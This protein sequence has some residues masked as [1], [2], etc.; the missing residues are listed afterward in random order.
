MA[1]LDRP[2]ASLAPGRNR[3]AT[4]DMQCARDLKVF[5]LSQVMHA[6]QGTIGYYFSGKSSQSFDG[7]PVCQL[8]FH[9]GFL[10]GSANCVKFKLRDMDNAQQDREATR[11]QTNFKAVVNFR[12]QQQSEEGQR[13]V[14]VRRNFGLECLFA[15]KVEQQTNQEMMGVRQKSMGNLH[16]VIYDRGLVVKI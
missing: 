1:T 6:R 11:F 3:V 16:Y 12:P 2:V 7:V 5:V 4:Y 8:Y 10:S 13:T 15:S 14:E 9:T